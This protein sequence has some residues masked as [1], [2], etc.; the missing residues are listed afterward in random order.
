LIARVKARLA[1]ASLPDWHFNL[2]ASVFEQ[3]NRCKTDFRAHHVNQ[4]GVKQAHSKSRGRKRSIPAE[5]GFDRRWLA[6]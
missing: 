4:T 2:A 5:F 6:C 3:P 1:A